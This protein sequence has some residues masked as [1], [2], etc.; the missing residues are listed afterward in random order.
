VALDAEKLMMENGTMKIDT[1]D[2]PAR[3]VLNDLETKLS[4]VKARRDKIIFEISRA[5]AAAG[6]GDQQARFAQGG[7]NK[8]ADAVGRDVKAGRLKLPAKGLSPSS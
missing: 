3:K 6:K 5:S 2:L 1:I 7:L 8:E 4:D